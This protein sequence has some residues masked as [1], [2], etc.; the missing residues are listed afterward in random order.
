MPM[1]LR[2]IR[3]VNLSGVVPGTAAIVWS[4]QR[5]LLETAVP[6]LWPL[7]ALGLLTG[8]MWSGPGLRVLGSAVLAWAVLALSILILAVM[9][10]PVLSL[11]VGIPL[12][13]AL[14][15][16]RVRLTVWGTGTGA[17][18]C[19]VDCVVE[20]V[21][22][23]IEAPTAVPV[24]PGLQVRIVVPLIHGSPLLPRSA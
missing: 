22:A 24:S 17:A 2:P 10:R 11:S 14:R 16:L 7:R 12:V 6:V 18:I 8:P 20:A 3:V 23:R 21:V 4:I 5:R 15:R 1:A 9:A 19:P 13:L